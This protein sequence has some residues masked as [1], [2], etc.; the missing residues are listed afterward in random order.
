VVQHAENEVLLAVL[1]RE[2]R[3]SGGSTIR[4]S[5]TWEMKGRSLRWKREKALLPVVVECRILGKEGDEENSTRRRKWGG[6]RR[7]SGNEAKR[8]VRKEG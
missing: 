6:V 5:E 2:D 1:Q 4:S 8:D 7:N 3:N